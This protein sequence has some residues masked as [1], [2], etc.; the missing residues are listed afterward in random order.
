MRRTRTTI[1]LFLAALVLAGCMASFA[2][3]RLD[4]LIP[5]YVDGYV[6]LTRDQRQLLKEQLAPSLQWH[7][8]EE[9][10]HYVEIL[11]RIEAGLAGPVDL[12]HFQK[13]LT[14]AC[15]EMAKLLARDAE[16]ATKLLI[17]KVKGASDEKQAIQ[18]AKSA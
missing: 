14:H 9:L 6:D 5:W 8:Q 1:T 3:N 18:M 2:Y 13:A 7:R 11:D 16:G 17:S 10:V 4:W 12:K 15:T